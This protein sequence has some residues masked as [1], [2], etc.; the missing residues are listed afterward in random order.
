MAAL[1]ICVWLPQRQPIVLVESELEIPDRLW[2]VRG[3]G[4]WAEHVCETPLDHWSYGLEAFALEID[5][6]QELLGRG[7]GTRVPLG[8]EL[9]FEASHPGLAIGETSTP[10]GG[11]S[12]ATSYRQHGTVHGL[13]LT[14]AGSIEFT[15]NGSRSHSWGSDAATA[16]DPPAKH[17]NGKELVGPSTRPVALPVPDHVLW[18]D[19]QPGSVPTMKSESHLHG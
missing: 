3:S 10:S 8:W 12:S 1:Q 2:E 4:L 9:E 14:K 15:G 17:G 19:Y 18:V 7:H 16:F 6:P 5:D 11:G 13:L